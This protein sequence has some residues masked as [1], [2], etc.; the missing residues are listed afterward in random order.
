LT[1]FLI[2]AIAL[3]AAGGVLGIGLGVLGN[4]LIYRTTGFFVP[5]SYT[6]VA[7]GFGFSA[8]IG[9]GFGYFPARKAAKLNPIDAL[10]YE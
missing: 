8:M 5:T 2:E 3:S 6:S 4:F 7:I 10:H 9:I 1:Q